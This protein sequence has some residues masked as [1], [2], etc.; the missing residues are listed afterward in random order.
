MRHAA[1]ALHQL[2]TA[3]VNEGFT[4]TQALA[5]VGYSLAAA[6]GGKS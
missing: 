2:Y 4:E 3:L 5:I 6:N 1:S